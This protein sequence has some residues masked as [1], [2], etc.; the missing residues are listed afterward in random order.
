[1]TTARSQQ[2]VIL[3]A[4]AVGSL[5]GGYLADAGVETVLVDT[6]AAHVE[7]IRTQGLVLDTPEGERRCRPQAWHFGEISRLRH[8]EP[9][10]AFLT[11]KLYD[12]DWSALLLAKWLSPVVPV[13]TLQNALVEE[14]VARAVGWGRTLGAVG[15]GLDVALS[16]PG[17]VRRSRRRASGTAPVFKVGELH[18]RR[19]LRA[20]QIAGLL[21]L[22]DRSEVTTDLWSVRWAKLCANVMTTGLSGLSGASLKEVYSGERTRRIAVTLAAEALA[23]GTALGF[24]APSIFG[25]S[26]DNWQAAGAGEVA[27]LTRA[28]EA[29]AAQASNMT[30]GGMSGTLQDLRRQ[31]PTEVYFFNGFSAREAERLGARAPVNATVAALIRQVEEGRAT[32]GVHN[33]SAIDSMLATA[34]THTRGA[35]RPTDDGGQVPT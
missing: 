1:M 7:T 17:R 30:E 23:V 11:V 12:T 35:F 32:I 10:A 4:G 3:G 6:W 16:G 34:G 22:V 24:E 28:M 14:I 21:G 9:T 15:S 19:T 20:E 8:L 31:R 27:A 29:M 25:L 26:A 5:V 33:L 18:G 2:V 13:V